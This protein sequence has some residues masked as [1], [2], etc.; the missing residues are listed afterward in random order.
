MFEADELRMLI[1][2]K[3]IVGATGPDL[4]R[5]DVALRAMILLGVNL[6]FGNTDCAELTYTGLNLDT[7]WLDFP[8]V[9]TGIARRCPLWP[10]TVA[11]IR[12]AT[13]ARPKPKDFADCGRVFLSERG[14][15]VVIQTAKGHKKDLVGVRFTNL[16]KALGLHRERLGFYT[17]RHV[18]ETI[19]G[20][21]KDQVAVDCIMGHSDPSMASAYRE[22]IE[23]DRLRAVVNHVRA[24]LWPDRVA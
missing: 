10:E 23:D 17:L 11:A 4:V 19:G 12:A 1:D 21:A 16:L 13:T 3:P 15:A 2:G 18:F 22:R 24:W 8:R 14:T 6:G 7:G 9:K 5:P 20:S